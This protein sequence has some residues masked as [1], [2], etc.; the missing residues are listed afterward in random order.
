MPQNGLTVEKNRFYAGLGYKLNENVALQV[1]N[2]RDTDYKPD[3]RTRKNYI[4]VLFICDF[5]N[6]FKKH[7]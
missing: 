6:L 1:G 3:S 7:M 5:T 2:M 4:Q